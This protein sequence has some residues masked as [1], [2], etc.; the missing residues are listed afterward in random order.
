L[1]AE[2]DAVSAEHLE[3]INEEGIA[4]MAQANVVA[5]SLPLASLYLREAYMPARKLISAG[6]GVAVATDF[7]PGSAPSFHLPLAMTLAC[8]NQGM[9]PSE[10]LMGATTIAARAINRQ[11]SSGSLQAGYKAD[12]ALIDAPDLNH[13]LYQFNDN[14]CLGVVKDGAWVYRHNRRHLLD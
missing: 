3:Y 13:W 11:D 14:A 1:A 7:N 2:M 10:S 5:V 9:T 6:V 12:F 8:L 4:A